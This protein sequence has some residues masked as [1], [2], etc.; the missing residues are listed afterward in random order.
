LLAGAPIRRRSTFATSTIDRL[1][2]D[3]SRRLPPLYARSA[4]A[5]GVVTPRCS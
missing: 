5:P 4:S 2:A 3:L 1:A